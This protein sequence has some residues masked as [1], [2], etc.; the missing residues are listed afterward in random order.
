M[1]RQDVVAGCREG[2][3]AAVPGGVLAA[4]QR[5]V[6][7][8]RIALGDDP[9]LAQVESALEKIQAGSGLLRKHNGHSACCVPKHKGNSAFCVSDSCAPRPF[10]HTVFCQCPH[11]SHAC[12]ILLLDRFRKGSGCWQSWR[13]TGRKRDLDF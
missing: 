3:P 13:Q 5:Y 1:P 4:L 7:C 11:Y 2:A 12:L 8:M 6:P 10:M 9:E